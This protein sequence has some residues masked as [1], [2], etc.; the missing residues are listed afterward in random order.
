MASIERTISAK[1]N[2]IGKSEIYI[3]LILSRKIRPRIKTG[4]YISPDRWRDG[5]FKYPRAN[6]K[7]SEEIRHTEEVLTE[8]E[9]FLLNLCCKTNPERLTS[10]FIKRAVERHRNPETPEK[11]VTFAGVLEMF[12][13]SRDFSSNRVKHYR[14]LALA[15]ERY[16][17]YQT[18]RGKR[19]KRLTPATTTPQDL[20]AFEVFLFD[21]GPIYDIYPEIYGAPRTRGRGKEKHTPRPKPRAKNTVVALMTPLRALFRWCNINDIIHCNPFDKYRMPRAMYG[22]PY[23]ITARERDII[24]GWDFSGDPATERQRDIFIFQCYIGCRVSDLFRMTESNVIGGAIEYIPHKTKKN[25]GEIIRVPLHPV[26]AALIEKHRDTRPGSRLFPFT[27]TVMYNNV[28]KHIFA[29]CGITRK[30]T[31]LNPVSGE[32]EQRPINEIAS[33]HLARRT[34]IGN[35]YKQ[36]KDP[37]LI[38]KLSGHV[39]GSTAFARYRDI[40]E[41]IKTDLIN[42]L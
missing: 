28:I 8:I 2:A 30:V 5:K 32:E 33:S 10:D 19:G 31:V 36:V 38:G 12:L 6:Q 9:Q 24:A 42:L 34:F 13:R 14:T 15:I 21:E 17:Q 29:T 27:S 40:D 39:E 41:E 16:N 26:A 23:Y 4:L 11:N 25:R 7:E 3:R 20:A 18:K 22:T 37:A 1:V 35:L